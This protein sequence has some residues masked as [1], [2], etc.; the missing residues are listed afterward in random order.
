MVESIRQEGQICIEN[1]SE[2]RDQVRRSLETVYDVSTS[3]RSFN[4]LMSDRFEFE[5]DL[6]DVEELLNE[7]QTRLSKHIEMIESVVS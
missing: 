7:V 4:R 5:R 6:N 3:N 2:L 1:V